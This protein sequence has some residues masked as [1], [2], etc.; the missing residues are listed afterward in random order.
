MAQEYKLRV[1][2]IDRF[3]QTRTFKT[4]KGAQ[5]FA[6]KWV[7]EHPDTSESFNY[8][9]SGDGVCKVTAVNF[10]IGELYPEPVE[11]ANYPEE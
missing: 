7:G 3:S 4:L 10:R 11:D 5:K 9:V 2:T 1:N 8:A 6:A